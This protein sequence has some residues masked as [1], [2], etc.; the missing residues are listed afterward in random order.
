MPQCLDVMNQYG[1]HGNDVRSMGLPDTL[2]DI[3]P[4]DFLGSD[5]AD[6]AL[7]A[8][9]I[10]TDVAWNS[11]LA[12]TQADAKLVFQGVSLQEVEATDGVCNDAPDCIPYAKYRQGSGF[13]RAYKIVDAN[14]VPE[15][16]TW[17]Q[18][19]GFSFGKKNGSNALSNNTIVKSA[20]SGAIVF[21]AVKDS[22][23]NAQAYA[24]VE[25]HGQF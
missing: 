20:V 6:S 18:G 12:T 14:G 23:P 3:C 7:V 25:F 1:H 21:R 8:K 19:Q 5:T 11:D 10:G 17:V 13:T 15:P 22:G 16:T 4:G 9:L 2:V 24:E